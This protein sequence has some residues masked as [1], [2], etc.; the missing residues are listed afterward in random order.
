[1]KKGIEGEGCCFGR[2]IW[3]SWNEIKKNFG[4][5]PKEILQPGQYLI[6]NHCNWTVTI[7]E[8][9]TDEDTCNYESKQMDIDGELSFLEKSLH[10]LSIDI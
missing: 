7:H 1:M 5:I 4:F 3:S 9:K 10:N 2:K 6:A 8:D